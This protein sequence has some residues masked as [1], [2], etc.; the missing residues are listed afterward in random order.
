MCTQVDHSIIVYL[1]NPDGEFVDY[2]GL[3]PTAP[4]IAASVISHM[5]KYRKTKALLSAKQW[6]Y[7]R[8]MN[9]K[10]FEIN[11]LCLLI[12]QRFYFALYQN[13]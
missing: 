5:H 9:E 11:L 2:Y 7:V 3:R 12:I 4:E 1:I 6:F 13:K 8:V 10:L